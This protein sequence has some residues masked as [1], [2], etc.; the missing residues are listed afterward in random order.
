MEDVEVVLQP[1]EVRTAEAVDHTALFHLAR[2]G[3][4]VAGEAEVREYA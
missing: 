3:A 4:N 2:N 1:E